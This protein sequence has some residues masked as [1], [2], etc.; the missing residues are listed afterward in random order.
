MSPEP[1]MRDS[2]APLQKGDVMMLTGTLAPESAHLG[3]Q[4]YWKAWSVVEHSEGLALDKT[5]R[6]AGWNFF[7]LAGMIRSYAIG[8]DGERTIRKAMQSVL[9]QVKPGSFNC[10]EVSDVTSARFCGIPYVRLTAHSRHMQKSG[11]LDSLLRRLRKNSTAA[12]KR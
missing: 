5:L 11:T 6:N 8:N 9:A 1:T 10:V 7:F 3:L 12:L 2:A 4:Q